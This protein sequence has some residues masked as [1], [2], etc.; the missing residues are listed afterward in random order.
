MDEPG[1]KSRFRLTLV[2]HRS[3]PSTFFNTPQDGPS[4][5]VAGTNGEWLTE[6][7]LTTE[8]MSSYLVAFVISDFKKIEKKSGLGKDVEVAAKPHSIDAGEGDF[9]LEEASEILDFFSDYFNVSYPL[10]KSSNNNHHVIG[11]ILIFY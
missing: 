11:Y 10:D 5:P 9:A 8:I 7:F 2:R 3:F 4:V 6:R 1:I